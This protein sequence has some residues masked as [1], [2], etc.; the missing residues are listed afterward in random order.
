[1]VVRHVV[2]KVV[3]YEKM[4]VTTVDNHVRKTLL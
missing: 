2:V 1:M 4:V 3:F